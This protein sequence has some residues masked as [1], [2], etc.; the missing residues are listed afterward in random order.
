MKYCKLC[1]FVLA[2][3]LSGC[4]RQAKDSQEPIRTQKSEISHAERRIIIEIHT[5]LI[6]LPEIIK[7][8]F[9]ELDITLERQDRQLGRYIF[10]GKSPAGAIVTIEAVSITKGNSL[11]KITAGGEDIITEPLLKKIDKAL[12]KAI[13]E[14]NLRPTFSGVNNAI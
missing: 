6:Q 8:V 14:K 1:I 10:T 13:N 9:K 12:E 2:I 5:H 11:L 3:G 4:D 7:T